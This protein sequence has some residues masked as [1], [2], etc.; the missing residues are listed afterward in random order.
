MRGGGGGT[1][2]FQRLQCACAGGVQHP[3]IAASP[4]VVQHA[5]WPLDCLR[6][7][8]V[9]RSLVRHVLLFTNAFVYMQ[10]PSGTGGLATAVSVLSVIQPFSLGCAR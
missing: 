8:L 5:Q 4:G 1:L 3:A 6:H 9:Y 2:R 7:L 10:V